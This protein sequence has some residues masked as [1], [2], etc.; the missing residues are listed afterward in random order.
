[1]CRDAINQ[2]LIT[3]MQLCSKKLASY[4]IMKKNLGEPHFKFIAHKKCFHRYVYSET[5]AYNK[6]LISPKL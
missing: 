2:K 5:S 4:A 1:M 6:V 3:G